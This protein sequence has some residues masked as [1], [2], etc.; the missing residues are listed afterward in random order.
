[1]IHETM[2]ILHILDHS[3]P[4]QSGYAF[5]SRNILRSQKG[6]GL[7]PLALTSPKHEA[8]WKGLAPSVHVIDG[9]VYHRSGSLDG[10]AGGIL[11]EG[12]LVW[13]LRSRIRRLMGRERPHVLHAH[14]PVL[15][16]LAAWVE[17]RRAG[18]P[19][20]YEIRA[21]WEDAAADLGTYGAASA[22]YRLVRALETV[23][24]RRADR[25]VT[26]C[27][28]LRDDLLS[29]GIP[30]EKVCVV[31]NAVDLSEFSVSG[32]ARTGQDGRFGKAGSKTVAFIGSFYHYEGL[33]LLIEACGRLVDRHRELRLLL[34]GGGPM[35]G[36]LKDLV[37]RRGLGE[38]V[39]F[40]GRIPHHQVVEAYGAADLLVYP[41]KSMRL[42]EL[43]TPLKPLEAM[44]L[45]KPVAASAVGGHRELIRHGQTGILFPPDDAQALAAAI[46]TLL[47]SEALRERLA[48]RA[49][50]WVVRERTWD[51]NGA[52]Y[53]ALYTQYVS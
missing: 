6:A 51:R 36:P 31:P 41:R 25:V 46:S 27:R 49:R 21:F 48:R 28:G 24:C 16:A 35:E 3:L 22:K 18:I 30:G 45:G 29:R 11:G 52:L 1:M 4:L 44:V 23:V 14:S 17:A 40:T 15:N 50:Q 38:S 39:V 5:R 26:I 20:I 7:A 13:R 53:R 19:M 12:A 9:I 47:D 2:K 33:D 42:T 37:A 34:V 10:R 43:V 8:S 32:K